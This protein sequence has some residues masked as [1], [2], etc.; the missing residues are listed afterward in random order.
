LLFADHFEAIVFSHKL[1][2]C[3]TINNLGPSMSHYPDFS[4]ISNINEFEC[5]CEKKSLGATSRFSCLYPKFLRLHWAKSFG[6][7]QKNLVVSQG[8]LTFYT[9]N[10]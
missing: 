7:K 8:S 4:Q 3:S 10:C 2:G 9:Q 1:Q 6:G 5:K